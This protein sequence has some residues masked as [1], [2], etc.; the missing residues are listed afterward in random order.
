VEEWRRRDPIATWNRRLTERGVLPDD[1]LEEIERE[2]AEQIDAAVDFADG[3][4]FPPPESLY[5]HIYVLGDQLQGWYSVDER[6]AGVHRG[7]DSRSMPSEQR[8]R[9]DLYHEEVERAGR[10]DAR[11]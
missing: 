9:E 6:S 4:D 5:D 7:E 1:A 11:S 8:A 10:E 3:S 2:V